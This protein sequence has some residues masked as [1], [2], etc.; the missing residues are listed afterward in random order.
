[1][2]HD[3]NRGNRLHVHLAVVQLLDALIEFEAVFG[4]CAK[5]FPVLDHVGLAGVRVVLELDEPSIAELLKWVVNFS[6]RFQIKKGRKLQQ[7]ITKFRGI[8]SDGSTN[9]ERPNVSR[10]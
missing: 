10:T 2:K 7:C 9:F 4:Y 8:S 1:M 5:Q 6:G 3:G